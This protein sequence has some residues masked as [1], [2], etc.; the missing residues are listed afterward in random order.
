MR[1]NA[2]PSYESI[3][4]FNEVYLRAVALSWTD[5]EFKESLLKNPADT[6]QRYFSYRLPWEVHLK[7]EESDTGHYA[8]GQ[9]I[10]LPMNG[11]RVGIPDAPPKFEEQ[12]V[13]LSLFNDS[14]PVYLFTCC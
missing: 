9:W 12:P 14:G 7:I 13:A 5:P 11:I 8:D 10:D 4:E 6:L 3:I 2:V 1:N